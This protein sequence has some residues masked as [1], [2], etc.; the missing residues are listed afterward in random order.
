MNNKTWIILK[1]EIFTL[2][3]RPSYWFA[4]LGIPL[5][6]AIV[7]AI[8]GRA[9][10]DQ[11][12]QQFVTQ[13]LTS[14][15]EV[16]AQGYVDLS[17]IIQR[18]PEGTPPD[19]FI[20]YPDEA[21]AEQALADGQINGYYLVPADYLQTG[22]I[23]NI[24][25]DFNP[26]GAQG[27]SAQFEWLIQYNLLDRD[28]QLASLVHGPFDLEEISLAPEPQ[29]D[30]DNPL[31]YFLPYGVTMIFYIVILSAAS[32]LL[33][34]MGKEKENRILEI[35]MV[36]I[37]P[38][39]MLAGKI[40]GLGVVGL[41]QIVIWLGTGRVLLAA[42]ET[43]FSLPDVFQLPL[44]FMVWGLI[45]FLLGYAVYAS[46]MAG[47]GALAPNLRDASQATIIVIMPLLVPMILINVLIEESHGLAA[48]ILSI[49]PLTA[50]VAMMT[51]LAGGGVPW[52]QPT[53]AAILLG[54]TAWLI[55]R[56]VAGLFHTQALLS[57]QPFKTKL[58]FKALLGKS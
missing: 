40:I 42:S 32:L 50:P 7:Y 34:S 31:T 46:L 35:L 41:L 44:S 30:E 14:P 27:Q 36:S 48:V 10:Q 43:T 15:Q 37:T 12:T 25:A 19:L 45:F 24:R 55:V 39:Q 6:S 49:F 3:S 13:L 58:F 22:E 17:G 26:L 4:I 16:Q 57:G 28:A 51:R 53:L 33:S 18:L 47:L 38:R 52:W 9:T 11:S 20:A 54:I 21:S 23:I 2:L 29:R 8:A 56:A 1:H 5:L